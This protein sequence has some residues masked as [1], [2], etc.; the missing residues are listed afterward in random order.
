MANSSARI[1]ATLAALALGAAALPAMA[2][3][4]PAARPNIVMIFCDDHAW[5][6]ISAYS[7]RLMRTPNIDRLA[8]EG[9]LFRNCHVPNPI[10]GPSR[11]CVLTGKYSHANGFFRNGNTFDGAQ[12][13]F[14]KALQQAGYETAIIG[15][16]HLGE[17]MAPQGFD[18][19]C[20]LVGQ[21]PYYNPKFLTDSD[22]DGLREEEDVTGYT[23][24]IVTDMALEWLGG[25]ADPQ[26]PFMLMLQHKAP[27]RPWLPA[28]RHLH[29]FEADTIP[30]PETLFETYDGMPRA[31][32]LSDMSIAYTM[33]ARDLKLEPMA[34]LNDEQRAA[35]DAAYGP[36]NEAF[37]AANPS[38]DD[39]T[40]WRYQRYMKDYLR[41]VKAIDENVGRVLD[42]LDESGLAGNTIVV[43]ASDQ[44][45]FLGEHGWF[46]K[47]WIYEE[48]LRT[49]FIVRWP[50]HAEPG[51]A[52][53]EIV[54]VIDV[55]PTFCEAA[56][57]PVPE[58]VHGRSIVPVLEGRT[59]ADWRRH[60]YFHYYEYPGW[61]AVRKHYG[62][63][64]GR[65]KLAYFYELDMQEWLL[66]DRAADPHERKNF[67]GDPAY[68]EVQ[69]R[70]HEAL[71]KLRAEL[72][73]TEEDPPESYPVGDPYR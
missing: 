64:D 46:D 21:G 68:A 13:T 6:A 51:S 62:V 58:D 50:G 36:R 8:S 60:F 44:G 5:Q 65:Y 1:R 16:W 61:H 29:D 41:C 40:R 57:A 4:V 47:R 35:W 52:A 69:T 54:S 10:C 14:P 43:Y 72:N 27:H 18:H 53:D 45:M 33:T 34:E 2:S 15:K 39:L 70:L 42:W 9:M 56:G 63:T 12:W 67:H 22:G 19:S 37:R 71:D 20:V 25:R 24:D 66:V 26:K 31:A 30:E 59:P 49:P 48:S 17:H 55:A 32:R 11:A 73:V 3:D 28:E 7:P 23:T 38:G